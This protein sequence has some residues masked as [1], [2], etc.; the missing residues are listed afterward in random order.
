MKKMVVSI[1]KDG[2]ATH[3]MQGYGDDS[4]YRAAEA[5]KNMAGRYLKESANTVTATDMHVSEQTNEQQMQF[6]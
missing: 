6:N 3:T 4:C 2:T 1:K 5:V